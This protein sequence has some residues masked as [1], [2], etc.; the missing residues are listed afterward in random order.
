MIAKPEEANISVPDGETSTICPPQGFFLRATRPAPWLCR[1]ADQIKQTSEKGR[2]NMDVRSLERAL[3]EVNARVLEL[4]SRVIDLE[5]KNEVLLARLETSRLNKPPAPE[6]STA[7][8]AEIADLKSQIVD[9]EAAAGRKKE[10][11]LPTAPREKAR[12]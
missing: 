2:E 8:E 12:R 3:N 4:S 9:L 5:E 10:K 6:V 1:S 11:L 7:A